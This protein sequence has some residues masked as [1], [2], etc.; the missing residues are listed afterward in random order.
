MAVRQN[1]GVGGLYP[2]GRSPLVLDL[3]STA[4]A[5]SQRMIKREE[6]RIAQ[7]KDYMSKSQQEILK[8]L[9]FE[10]VQGLSDNIQLEHLKEV[11]GL[12]AKWAER[13][14]AND[15]KLNVQQLAELKKDQRGVE[16]KL[17][18]MQEDVK[19]VAFAQNELKKP[20]AR[21]LWD[22][23][24]WLNLKDYVTK[25]MVGSGGAMEILV[26]REPSFI[27]HIQGTYKQQ[28]ANL[29]KR[30]SMRMQGV[31]TEEGRIMATKDNLDAANNMWEALKQQPD[32]SAYVEKIGE[33]SAKE[34]FLNAYGFSL[35]DQK[36]NSQLFRAGQTSASSDDYYARKYGWG[37]LPKDKKENMIVVNDLLEKIKRVDKGALDELKSYSVK[38]IGFPADVYYT[39]D[40][41]V[42]E[43]FPKGAAGTIPK[44]EI[45]WPKDPTSERD[46][47]NFKAKVWENVNMFSAGQIPDN[48]TKYIVPNWE[49]VKDTEFFVP[50]FLQE[51]RTQL[52][53]G[54]T[55][56]TFRKDIVK[57]IKGLMPDVDIRSRSNGNKVIIRTPE[58]NDLEFLVGTEAGKK[59]LL[60]WFNNKAA[61]EERFE[62]FQSPSGEVDAAKKQMLDIISEQGIK[63]PRGLI[64]YIM[65][66]Y[67]VDEDVASGI[68]E[69]AGITQ[70]NFE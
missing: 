20:T 55:P 8:A 33:E 24:S 53:T 60:E 45:P 12:T 52:E 68:I 26:P 6:Q 47:V 63:E 10:V 27:E 4:S 66:K 30:I 40:G 35:A 36:F 34:Q 46:W 19:M 43:G 9:D 58:G 70:S 14:A 7:D 38:N 42:I 48:K 23:Q 59:S 18:K 2:T 49:E 65:D 41:L 13:Y 57:S 17:G 32:V 61:W 50:E 67:D 37:G 15:G 54:K 69:D 31:N 3:G 51:V 44:L 22:D 39:K 25:G 62:G 16:A 1:I 28:M 5:I 21:Q 29:E 56:G 11:D 64:E